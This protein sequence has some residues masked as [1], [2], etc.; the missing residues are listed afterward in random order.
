MTRER[1]EEI[2]LMIRQLMKAEM[3]HWRYLY[4][5]DFTKEKD[6]IKKDLLSHID[7]VKELIELF[8]KLNKD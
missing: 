2:D 3:N 1:Q 6:Y 7:K 4:I 5:F 8:D